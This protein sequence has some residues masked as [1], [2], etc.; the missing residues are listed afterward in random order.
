[1]RDDPDGKPGVAD[2]H[3]IVATMCGL[4]VFIASCACFTDPIR[5]ERFA[6]PFV[7]VLFAATLWSGLFGLLTPGSRSGRALS[8]LGLLAVGVSTAL[9]FVMA[10]I[11]RDAMRLE[12]R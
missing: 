12:Q 2:A 1:M 11:G 6:L 9:M 7:M 5:D 3:G 4:G 10:V 8:A